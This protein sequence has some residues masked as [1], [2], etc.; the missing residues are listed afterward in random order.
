MET[1]NDVFQSESKEQ[2]ALFMLPCVLVGSFLSIFDQFVINVAATSIGR[3]L[4]PSAAELEGIVSGYALMYALGLITGGRIGDK[5]GRQKIYRTGLL[6]FTITSALCGISQT[7]EQLVVARLLQGISGAVMVPQVLA[8]IRVT[9][10]GTARV[11]ALS[12]FG[13]SIG[14]GQICGQLLG[15]LIPSWD[16]FGLGWRPIFLL[17]IPICLIAFFSVDGHFRKITRISSKNWI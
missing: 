10:E 7:S 2:Q 8:L 4:Q 14:M 9:F 12:L 16:L 11:R 1:R 13:V 17:N 15:G 5:Y 6:L 3:A